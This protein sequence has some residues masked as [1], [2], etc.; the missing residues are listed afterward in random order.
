[1]RT[2]RIKTRI[3]ALA[4]TAILAGVGLYG[5]GTSTNND[6]GVSFTLLGFFSEFPDEGSGCVDLPAGQVGVI[7]P[8]SSGETENGQNASGVLTIMGLQNNLSQVFVRT[9][10]IFIDYYIEGASMQPPSTTQTTSVIMSPAVDADEEG[11]SGEEQ[12]TTTISPFDS[13]LPPG[14]GGV[15]CS[16]NFAQFFIVPP[17][18]SAWVNL[19]RASLPEAPF[20]MTAIVKVTGVTSAGDRLTTNEAA[21]DVHFRPDVVIPPT[22]ST[23]EAEETPT[24]ESLF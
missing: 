1:M 9:E 18:I 11:S 12:S 2:L 6:Q 13:S 20:V 19:H 16:R 4:V 24:E 3:I 10:R 7:A 23:P 21:F 22:N 15:S 5:C 14:W 17:D 8:L